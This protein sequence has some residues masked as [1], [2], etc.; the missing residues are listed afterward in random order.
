MHRAGI[1]GEVTVSPINSFLGDLRVGTLAR[2]DFLL[3]KFKRKIVEGSNGKGFIPWE[4][5]VVAAIAIVRLP[6]PVTVTT[7][8]PCM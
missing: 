2:S 7:Y 5:P 1:S 3:R 8:I 4:I 6:N